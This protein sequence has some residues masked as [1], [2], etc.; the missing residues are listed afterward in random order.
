MRKRNRPDL[1]TLLILALFVGLGAAGVRHFAARINPDAIS[2]IAVAEHLLAGRWLESV[3]GYWA[4]LY[5]WLMAPLLAVGVAAPLAGRLAS[6]A[7]GLAA[8]G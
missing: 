2:Y 3:N 7:A 5:P 1:P 6:L 4:P 8:L